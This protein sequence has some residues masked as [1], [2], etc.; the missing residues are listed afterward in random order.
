MGNI[1]KICDCMELEKEPKQNGKVNIPY[2]EKYDI[3]YIELDDIIKND[4]NK[5]NYIL[6]NTD[7]GI[8]IMCY[9]I[10]NKSFLYFCDKVV[11]NTILETVS[12]KYVIQFKCKYIYHLLDDSDSDEDNNKINDL[13]DVYG[14]FKKTKN[15]KRI[16]IKSNINKYKHLGKLTAFAFTKNEIKKQNKKN[17]VSYK[18]FN[19]LKNEIK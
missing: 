19:S 12:K 8:I 5:N 13:P 2:N 10:E 15:V 17:I 11:P 14:K 7:Y 16:K 18:E 6:E 1:L 4:V 9:D 3:K